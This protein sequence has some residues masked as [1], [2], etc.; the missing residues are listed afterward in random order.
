MHDALLRIANS[1]E[2]SEQPANELRGL[3]GE[4]ERL[5]ASH[6]ELV[7]VVQG[8]HAAVIKYID[9]DDMVFTGCRAFADK[10]DA[11]LT[12]ATSPTGEQQ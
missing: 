8:F 7:E 2:L 9:S 6:R 12:A 5:T 10:C 3:A 11:A 1:G 4:V